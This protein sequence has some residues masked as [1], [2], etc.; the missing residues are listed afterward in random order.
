[1]PQSREGP[2]C[3]PEAGSRWSTIKA[4]PERDSRIAGQPHAEQQARPCACRRALSSF[5]LLHSAFTV[6]LSFV[7]RFRLPHARAALMQPALKRRAVA[8][9]PNQ[10]RAG[11]APANLTASGPSSS[12]SAVPAVGLSTAAVPPSCSSA[13]DDD[14]EA[15]WDRAWAA[16]GEEEEEAEQDE[17]GYL[18]GMNIV[19]GEVR[20]DTTGNE[21]SDA[22]ARRRRGLVQFS[23]GTYEGVE[24]SAS[25]VRKLKA[26]ERASLLASRKLVLVLDLDHTL[27]NSATLHELSTEQ[28]DAVAAAAGVPKWTVPPEP[29]PAVSA[30]AAELVVEGEEDLIEEEEDDE[31][32]GAAEEVSC[33]QEAGG[34]HAAAAGAVA[35]G[36]VAAAPGAAAASAP[37]PGSSGSASA[38]A[39]GTPAVPRAGAVTD[40]LHWLPQLGLWT[41]L[42]PGL[43]EFLKATVGQFELYVYTMGARRYAAAVVELL[44]PDGGLGLRGKDR[45]IASEDSTS[46]RLKGLDVVLGAE[47]TTVS[48]K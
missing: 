43:R 29:A 9:Q 6:S 15:A 19:T 21:A 35:A 27:L 28:A 33:G 2:T 32:G 46:R 31:G 7:F 16:D 20:D 13:G 17:V 5:R 45:V 48:Q 3:Q 24:L 30:A 40:G 4:A 1:M 41:K 36:G 38:V 23:Y 34:A 11:A 10:A 47:E 12:S 18:W 42:R 8:R 44:D 39:T 37:G 26:E 25:E 14:S 22:E